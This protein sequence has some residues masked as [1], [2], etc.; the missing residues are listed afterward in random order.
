MKFF[1]RA[2]A[3]A[4]AVALGLFTSF[5]ALAVGDE[6]RAVD[7]AELALKTSSVEKDA[8]AEALFWEVRLDDSSEDLILNHYIRIKIFTERG[9][10]TQS[11]V[12][13]PFGKFFGEETKIKDIA[14]RTI[15]A[16]GTIIELQ[17]ED[18]FESTQIKASGAKIKVKAFAVP[19]IEAGAIIEYRWREVRI[20]TYA[21]RIHLDYQRDVP[22]QRV[23]YLLK[24]SPRILGTFR[25]QM[26]NAT[27]PPMQKEK[28]GF[29]SVTL[30]NVPAFHEE[31]RMPPEDQVKAWMF[32]YYSSYDKIDP[33]KY[34]RDHAKF[35]YEAS[36]E[37]TKVN[38][39]VRRAAAEA[40]G[41]AATPEDKLRRIFDYCRTKIKNVN[42]DTLKLTPEQRAKVKENK[43]P[44]DTLKRGI[45]DGAD[46]DGLFAALCVAAG[47][48]A[49]L[50]AVSNRGRIFFRQDFSDSYF[51]RG[52]D[53]AV[54]VG[55]Q[56]R[57]FDPASIYVPYGMLPWRE[58]G[59]Q[60]L[61]A[62]AKETNWVTTPQSTPEKSFEKR[63]GKFKLSEDGTLEGD[64]RVEYTGHTGAIM[65]EEDGAKSESEREKELIDKV[66]GRLSSAEVTV[67]GVENATDR[68][69]PLIYSYHV[70]VPGYAERT[71][72]RLFLRPG[73]FTRGLG[74][75]FSANERKNDIYFHYPWS[76]RDEIR[77]ELPTG[78]ALDNADA[79]AP[80]SPSMTQNICGQTIKMGIEDRS[81]TLIYQRDFFFGGRGNILFPSTSYVALKNL[82]DIVQKADDHAITLK[83]AVA[84]N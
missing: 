64:V 53:V 15:K 16:D 65:K 45:G 11:K 5:A 14:A 49:R 2:L 70:K 7:P 68:N 81:H 42:D 31:P 83:Q 61:L 56:W 20:A 79:P 29:Y 26:F 71:G 18:V 27:L 67:V 62:D 17:K 78:F 43:T 73:F 82:F 4:L 12:Q 1:P 41:D 59:L 28:D 19:G 76:E 25:V 34:W 72:K 58:E 63:T 6:W 22:V 33:P 35:L 24:P 69:K 48:D 13:I 37:A 80:V 50:T 74:P 30:T 52:L 66:K 21:N 39:E 54:K 32:V 23:K 9:K 84:S 38:D 8:D 75:L 44:S 51:L 3:S 40:I 77:I 10:E 57:F 36:K 47:F 55:E 60:A 46:I